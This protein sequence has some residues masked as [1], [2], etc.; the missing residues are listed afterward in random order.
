MYI[1]L[2]T[3]TM[4]G[5]RKCVQVVRLLIY[6]REVTGSILGWQAGNPE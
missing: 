6:M 1:N 3:L 5:P 2:Y 4:V